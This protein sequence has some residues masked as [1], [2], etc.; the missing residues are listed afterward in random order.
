M[1]QENNKETYVDKEHIKSLRKE[2]KYQE[3]YDFFKEIHYKHPKNT[4]V[5]TQF[6]ISII[7]LDPSRSDEIK[8]LSDKV[9]KTKNS[10]TAHLGYTV[11]YL[12]TG[13]IEQAKE[14]YDYIRDDK[15]FRAKMNIVLGRIK[16]P[17]AFRRH[18]FNIDDALEVLNRKDLKETRYIFVSFDV[19]EFYFENQD[20]DSAIKFYNKSLEKRHEDA[21]GYCYFKIAKCYTKLRDF[22][23]ADEY[24]NKS[25]DAMKKYKKNE[26]ADEFEYYKILFEYILCLIDAN[27]LE[28]AKEKI[29]LLEK[30]T[31][32]DKNL[33]TYAKAKVYRIEE[34]FEEAEK[35]LNELKNKT[36][37]DR[38][39]ALLELIQMHSWNYNI[40]IAIENL[41]EYT[42]EFGLDIN[43]LLSFFYDS[44]DYDK[45]IEECKKYLN[46]DYDVV[47]RFY[48]AKSYS[49][50][51]DLGNA[52][53]YF[54]EILYKEKENVYFEL[55]IIKAR[56]GKYDESYDMFSKYINKKIKHHDKQGFEK[57]IRHLVDLLINN[58][59]FEE[60]KGYIEAYHNLLGNETLTNYLY[61]KY[62]YRKQDYENAIIY[63]NKLYGTKYENFAKNYLV[64]IN[65]NNGNPEKSEEL[66]KELEETDYSNEAIFNSAKLD[67]DKHD[68]ASLYGAL[69]KLKSVKNSQIENMVISEMIGILLKLERY[70]KALEY[71]EEG[72]EKYS[73][74]ED[75][76]KQYKT[77]IYIKQGREDELSEEDI[78]DVFI[79]LVR[80]YDITN[81]LKNIY[82]LDENN[83]NRHPLYLSEFDLTDVYVELLLTLENY[84]Y[85]VSG[86]YDIY[87]IDMGRVIGNFHGVDTTL[88]EV[89]CEHN[90]TN[91]HMM[92]PTLKRINVNKYK[93]YTRKRTDL[94]D[95]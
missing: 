2:F 42:N 6:L 69:N 70:D 23:K 46:G 64:I 44:T 68:T 66:I 29:S 84:N 16:C 40:N 95:K 43:L 80:Y 34:N 37:L 87:I 67:E 61:S 39:L 20:Y 41:G 57:G 38:K 54:E 74:P 79:S 62:Y 7:D 73:F 26:K 50:K 12:L 28:V 21:K 45:T 91:I 13:D 83:C 78:D 82:Y 55:A 27:R 90:T 63:L 77:Y 48:M 58:Y 25:L 76:Y 14:H 60:A 56:L 93:E 18:I 88:L 65:R 31:E 10:N 35:L 11:Y 8:E 15:R 49:R 19:A 17:V 94:E 24:F 4:Y 3:V 89:K 92:Q 30:G 71:L 51:G 1:E 22:D 9:I 47:A 86:L 52:E 53:K 59:N 85:Y 72:H 5:A 33:A 36:P 81:A 75:F 32:K